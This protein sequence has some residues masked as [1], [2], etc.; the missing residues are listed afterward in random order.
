MDEAAQQLARFGNAAHGRDPREKSRLLQE[1]L[2]ARAG[3]MQPVRLRA[4]PRHVR[5]VLAFPGPVNHH[6]AR[7][8]GQ[9]PPRFLH[10]QLSRPHIEQ[11]IIRSPAR[12]QRGAVRLPGDGE[13]AI[14]DRD[15]L[16]AHAIAVIQ[17][18]AANGDH[19]H[20]SPLP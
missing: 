18:S 6:A 11:Q 19:A 4:L 2:R 10:L 17:I 16:A 12:A 8:R 7:T 13:P 15:V 1:F 9:T 5:V 14:V 20:P 3:K